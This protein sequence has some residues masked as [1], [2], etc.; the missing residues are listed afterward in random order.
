[1]LVYF[2]LQQ[3]QMHFCDWWWKGMA[4]GGEGQPH[5]PSA[6]GCQASFKHP[7]HLKTAMSKN[8][9][10]ALGGSVFREIP[11]ISWNLPLGA[12]RKT[13]K[14]SHPTTDE[15]G[16]ITLLAPWIPTPALTKINRKVQGSQTSEIPHILTSLHSH[17]PWMKLLG[18]LY[19]GDWA[20]DGIPNFWVFRLERTYLQILNLN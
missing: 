1:M 11:G 19:S 18:L 4:A 15:K 2:V 13:C 7:A 12:P 20:W 9:S 17:Q 5:F 10:T 8:N 6:M 14:P 3:K 16:C